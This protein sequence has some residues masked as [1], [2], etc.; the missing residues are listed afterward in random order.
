MRSVTKE[1]LTENHP[2]IKMLRLVFTLK[3]W[4]RDRVSH[5]V[6]KYYDGD[7]HALDELPALKK[8]VDEV[9]AEYRAW[10]AGA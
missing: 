5:L 7:E 2:M 3:P 10:E 6:A 9:F 8:A 4:G 1:E